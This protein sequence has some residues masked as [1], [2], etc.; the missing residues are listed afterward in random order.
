MNKCNVQFVCGGF[1]CDF[2]K[3]VPSDV[4]TKE[5]QDNRCFYYASGYC[6]CVKAIIKAL[7]DE[8]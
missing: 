6:R 2:V 8:L 4:T 1:N 5:G 7:Q 3:E